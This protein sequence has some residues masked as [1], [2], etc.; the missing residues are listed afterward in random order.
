MSWTSHDGCFYAK[1][2]QVDLRIVKNMCPVLMTVVLMLTCTWASAQNATPD[3]ASTTT[4]KVHTDK[5]IHQL[6][7]HWFGVA[8]EYFNAQFSMAISNQRAV[9]MI[10]S[11][12]PGFLRW[13]SGTCALWYFWDNPNQ[14][15]QPIAGNKLFISPN[16]FLNVANTLN[17][18]SLVQVNTYQIRRDGVDGFDQSKVLVAPGNIK[19]AANYAARWVKDLQE[20]KRNVTWW[21][22]GNE[23][24]VYYNGH[25]HAGFVNAYSKAMRK[26][27]PDIRILAQGMMA[28]QRW[29]SDYNVSMGEVWMDQLLQTLEPGSANAVSLHT[30]ISGLLPGQ[31]TP[32]L[33][34]QTMAMF[35]QNHDARDFTIVRDLVRSKDAR[36][37]LWLTEFNFMQTDSSGPGGLR[38]LQNLAHALVVTDRAARFLSLGA[39]RIAY[40]D[41]VGHPCFAMMDV[42][43][44]GKPDQPRMMAPGM[45]MQALT[46][47]F[48]TKLYQVDVEQAPTQS[49]TFPSFVV[50]QAGR[51]AKDASY[52]VVS[53]YAAGR[54][55]DN[56]TRIL[57]I[58]RDLENDQPVRIELPQG[59]IMPAWIQIRQLGKD[60]ALEANNLKQAEV[61][62]WESMQIASSDLSGL[63]LPAHSM[64]LIILP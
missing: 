24:W 64:S 34:Q 9:D 53:A 52:P 1:V 23:D 58:N 60:L 43:H 48:G 5:V 10:K 32:T 22:I 3:K 38:Q 13:P 17:A 18:Q 16:D 39:D 55:Q 19:E 12:K 28:G 25:Q 50:G 29:S 26:E 30:Y 6:D 4:I 40:H 45:G 47:E 35:A 63:M 7:E 20:K 37:Q 14:S 27:N 61:V 49:A 62:H 11:F 21:E 42:Q 46:S 59:A 54:K 44:Y 31:A 2:K 33:A 41:L 57:L 15:Y 8:G 51:T 56:T 36:L